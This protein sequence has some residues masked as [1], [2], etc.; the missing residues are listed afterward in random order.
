VLVVLLALLNIALITET[1]LLRL[2]FFSETSVA[3]I[4]RVP[5]GRELLDRFVI[6]VC[7]LSIG[8]AYLDDSRSAKR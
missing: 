5:Y 3:Y 6:I 7:H 1:S 4:S 8:R 2:D